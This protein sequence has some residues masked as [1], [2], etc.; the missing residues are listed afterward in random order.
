[1]E[2]IINFIIS[3]LQTVVVYLY[4]LVNY[5]ITL[6]YNLLNSNGITQVSEQ[7]ETLFTPDNDTFQIWSLIYQKLTIFTLSYTPLILVDN[8]D[9]IQ[10]YYNFELLNKN[11]NLNRQWITDFTVNKDFE[12][13]FETLFFLNQSVQEIINSTKSCY[14]KELLYPLLAWSK[15]ATLQNEI[16]FLTYDLSSNQLKVDAILE[17]LQTENSKFLLN[18][19]SNHCENKYNTT[20]LIVYLWAFLG[21]Y[22]T[23]LNTTYPDIYPNPWEQIKQ[24]VEQLINQLIQ[25]LGIEFDGSNYLELELN[26]FSNFVTLINQ[27]NKLDDSSILIYSIFFYF[28]SPFIN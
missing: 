26:Q 20:E 17:K 18:N 9:V 28:P 4:T 8:P 10:S 3:F 11:L 14:Y 24:L 15:C 21:I 6:A 16:I 19:F 25:D 7:T 12:K 13:S 1:M 5:I 2:Q 27:K 22:R 23:I